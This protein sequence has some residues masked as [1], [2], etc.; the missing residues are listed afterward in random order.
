MRILIVSDTHRRN[1]NYLRVLEDAGKIDMVIHCGDAEGSEFLL[2]KAADCPLHIVMGNND[3]FS[4]LP[5]E[6]ELNI[7]GKKVL[8][9]HGHYYC[10]SNGYELLKD[11]GKARGFDVVMYGHTH[12][13]VIDRSDDIAIINPGS[14]TYPRQE[15]RRPSY[16][17]METD[18]AGEMDFSLHYLENG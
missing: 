13:P 9:T 4:D 17:I 18:R 6:T 14:L 16:I 10:V 15:G 7:D 5:T 3:F 12:R 11:E 8:I 1:E 2:E